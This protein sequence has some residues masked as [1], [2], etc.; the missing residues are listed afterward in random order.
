M[1]NSMGTILGTLLATATTSLISL[2]PFGM[3]H[4]AVDI[5]EASVI[6]QQGQ[7]LKVAV[8]YASAPGERVPVTR[9]SV[10]EVSSES[11]GQVPKAD[12]F[13]ISQPATRN[14]LYL[15]SKEI[16]K[17]DKL[18]LVMVAADSPGKNV[19]FDLLVPPAKSAAQEV[20]PKT[21]S[22]AKSSKARKGSK[23]KSMKRRSAAK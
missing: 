9:F 17:I 18:K 19:V 7:R 10:S 23:A 22:K 2:A 20:A 1:N 4:S 14:V 11:T 5:G 8:T 12:Q 3:A 13:T 21:T 15:Q 16:V 6:S